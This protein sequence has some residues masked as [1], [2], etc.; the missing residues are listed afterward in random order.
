[1]IKKCS[2][3]TPTI[4]PLDPPRHTW[5]NP[6]FHCFDEALEMRCRPFAFFVILNPTSMIFGPSSSCKQCMRLD[7]NSKAPS[8]ILNRWCP[9]I[10]R[11][12]KQ[13]SSCWLRRTL[14]PVARP[15]RQMNRW[16]WR[17]RR[18]GVCETTLHHGLSLI[19]VATDT[20]RGT[21]N[22]VPRGGL[23][24]EFE[25]VFSSCSWS[26]LPHWDLLVEGG[27]CIFVIHSQCVFLI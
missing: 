18:P 3:P 5:A 9:N 25:V 21:S 2:T 6:K 26:C 10:K 20:L 17:Q 24:I 15:P 4:H 22:L 12:P 11:K 23:F 19:E 27:T 13:E 14:I 8:Q 16:N 1:M 7:N